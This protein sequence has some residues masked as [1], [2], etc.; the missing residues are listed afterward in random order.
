MQ[1]KSKTESRGK[2]KKLSKLVEI[3]SGESN[4]E[5][6]IFATPPPIPRKILI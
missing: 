2:N 5:I 1:P 4:E 3:N 6:N